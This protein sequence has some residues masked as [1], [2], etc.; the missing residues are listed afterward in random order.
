LQRYELARPGDL[1]H[2]DIKSLARF[3]KV[4]Q[5]IIGDRQQGLST[6]A[7]Y[8][9]VHGAICNPTRLADA[10]VLTNERSRR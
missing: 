1:I 9:K 10:E 8:D 3:L 7:G 4:G 6:G 5:R 2:I